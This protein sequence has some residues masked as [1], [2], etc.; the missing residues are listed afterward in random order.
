MPASKKIT[1]SLWSTRNSSTLAITDVSANYLQLRGL[2]RHFYRLGPPLHTST[3][4]ESLSQSWHSEFHLIRGSLP[5]QPLP[6]LGLQP[7]C[8]LLRGGLFYFFHWKRYILQAVFIPNRL[9]LYYRET[10]FCFCTSN[11]GTS[12]TLDFNSLLA[13][14]LSAIGAEKVP[15]MRVAN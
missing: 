10:L 11:S 6:H 9:H 14:L 15:Y 13:E 7:F 8:F 5:A 2:S 4:L 12:S 3:L 1:C